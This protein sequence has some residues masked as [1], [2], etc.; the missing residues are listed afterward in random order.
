MLVFGN[1]NIFI[2]A[3]ITQHLVHFIGNNVCNIFVYITPKPM[4]SYVMLVPTCFIFPLICAFWHLYEARPTYICPGPDSNPIQSKKNGALPH[5]GIF[6]LGQ[7]L[8]SG[9]RVDI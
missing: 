9:V 7:G 8:V 4:D 1:K 5:M 3:I 6:A 2:A